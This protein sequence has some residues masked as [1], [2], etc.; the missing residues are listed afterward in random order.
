MPKL[1]LVRHAQ[2]SFFAADYDELSALGLK[3]AEAL[4]THWAR[5]GVAFEA[6]FVGPRRRHRQTCERVAAAYRAQGLAFPDPRELT[7]L[8]E[9]QG[10]AIIKAALGKDPTTAGLALHATASE[11]AAGRADAVREFFGYYNSIMREWAQGE[12]ALEGV[13]SWAEFRARTLAALDLLCVGGGGARVAFTSGGF[14]SSAVGWLLALD[15]DRVIDLSL[16][17]S[18]TALSEVGW[19][20]RRRRLVSFNALPHLTDPAAVTTV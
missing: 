15:E 9:H 11:D 3:Q 10:P 12:H 8:D 14:V 6:V 17:L 2:A 1:I 18:N 5:Q 4:G 16:V 19:S 13:E 20:A 7:E